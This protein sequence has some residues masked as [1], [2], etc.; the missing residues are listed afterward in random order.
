MLRDYYSAMK[1]AFNILY[2]YISDAKGIHHAGDIG[3]PSSTFD[4][5]KFMLVSCCTFINYLIGVTAK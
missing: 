3:G 5:A 4:E 2:G 1:S